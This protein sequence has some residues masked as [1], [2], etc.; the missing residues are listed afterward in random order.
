V[1]GPDPGPG[2]AEHWGEDGVAAVLLA[3]QDDVGV[4][5]RVEEEGHELVGGAVQGGMDGWQEKGMVGEDVQAVGEGGGHGG[6]EG[7]AGAGEQ[8]LQ[9]AP[10]GGAGGEAAGPGQ[11]VPVSP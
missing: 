10:G 4:G 2:E 1:G 9:V 8:V 7:G 11:A 3:E 6:G 5:G